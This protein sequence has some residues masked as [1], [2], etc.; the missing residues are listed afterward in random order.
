GITYIIRDTED[1]FY[2]MRFISYYNDLGE[3]GYPV[4]EHSRL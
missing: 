2:K 4:I 3:K 1:F